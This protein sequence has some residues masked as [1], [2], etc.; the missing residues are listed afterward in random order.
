MTHITRKCSNCGIE[1]TCDKR[2]RRLCEDCRQT[3]HLRSNRTWRMKHTNTCLVCNKKLNTLNATHCRK[4]SHELIKGSNSP[5]WRG[6]RNKTPDGYIKIYQG[7]RT[8]YIFEHRLVWEQTN[9]KPLPKGWII[10]HLNSS[11]YFPSALAIAF[12][13]ISCCVL[14]ILS[15]G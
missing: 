2:G 13:I 1:F 7:N 11:I 8:S 5:Q 3:R 15:S 14:P 6:G 12:R 4:C 10:H 9:K